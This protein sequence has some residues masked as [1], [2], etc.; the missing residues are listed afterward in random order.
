MAA[1]VVQIQWLLEGMRCQTSPDYAFYRYGN[2]SKVFDLDY[3]G[4]GGFIYALSSK[5]LFWESDMEACTSVGMTNLGGVKPAGSLSLL[6]PLF[7]SLC[8]GAFT[9]TLS[10]TLQGRPPRLDFNLLELSFA[11]NE[12]ESMIVKLFE[13]ALTGGDS[14]DT[15]DRKALIR[16]TNTSPDMLLIA[17]IWALS[18]MS[19]MVWGVF[20][21]RHKYRLIDT[22]FWG[23]AYFA[24]ISRSIFLMWKHI[25]EHELFWSGRIPLILLMGFIPHFLVVSGMITCAFIYGAA[26]IATTFSLP[27]AAGEPTSF[28][29]RLSLAYSNLQAN[30]HFSNAGP[31][32]F[33]LTDDFYTALLN[34]GFTILTAASE[35]VYLNEGVKLRVNNST[36]L[37]QKRIQELQQGLLFKRTR[38]ALPSEVR[39]D[40]DSRMDSATGN[41]R[42][43]GYGVERKIRG[44]TREDMLAAVKGGTGLQEVEARYSSRAL[45]ATRLMLGT[46]WLV[47]GFN[48][49]MVIMSLEACGI[50]WRPQI[51]VRLMGMPKKNT[52]AERPSK[53]ELQRRSNLLV[54]PDGEAAYVGRSTDIEA[55]F[56]KHSI[57]EDDI[58]DRMYGWWK[59][60]GTWGDVDTSGEYT[61]STHTQDD[62]TTSMI[63]FSTSTTSNDENDWED[64]QDS[65]RRTPTQRNPYPS[66]REATPFEYD[67][68]FD[69]DQLA[70]LLD[71]KTKEEQEEAR[72]LSR[73]LRHPGT[74]TRSQYARTLASERA[75]LLTSSRY[76]ARL[77]TSTSMTPQEEEAALERFIIDRRAQVSPKNTGGD[78][79]SGAAGMGDAGPQCVVCQDSPRTVLLWPCGCLCLCDEC[80]VNMAARN[81]GTCICCRTGTLAYSRLYVP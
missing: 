20:G 15:I 23:I 19:S 40:L 33:K 2:A 1:I 67:G 49:K 12:A 50:S 76:G 6:W 36:W 59:Q 18:S 7:L 44:Q 62:D 35:A 68:A 21:K 75:A 28:K 78:W 14:D 42:P 41:T 81:F 73:R 25:P 55:E 52:P 45:M 71:P 64:E 5:A 26:L 24:A 16:A 13:A 27:P 63:S 80:R 56:N 10:S 53:Q 58:D 66:S 29:E 9:D 17:L 79:A 32:G 57:P 39:P 37:E 8:M 38:D 22:G 54:F 46:F 61:P 43:S 11:F 3:A 77:P 48:A 30:V 72:I 74:M 34:T 31:V 4:E 51:L 60:G 65:G 47:A 70:R 69:G